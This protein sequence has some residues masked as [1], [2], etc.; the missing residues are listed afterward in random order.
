MIPFSEELQH[1]QAYLAVESVLYGNRLTV[2][3]DIQVPQFRLPP[4]T[5]QPIVEN[6]VKY[7]VASGHAPGIITVRT[8]SADKGTE[9]IVEDNGPGFDPDVPVREG[10]V[11]LQNVRERLT[12]MCS[13]TIKIAPRREGGTIVTIF[14][15]TAAGLPEA[16]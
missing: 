11:G 4:L 15:P 16:D 14:V 7:G 6:S 5:L 1:T 10:H 3:Y 9:I 8:R 13:G 2:N 12:W